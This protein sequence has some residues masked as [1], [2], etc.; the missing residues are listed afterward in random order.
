MHLTFIKG[1]CYFFFLHTA[2]KALS[3]NELESLETQDSGQ[4]LFKSCLHHH[5]YRDYQQFN[6]AFF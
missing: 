4:I 6:N 1:R 3:H 5:D 2:N